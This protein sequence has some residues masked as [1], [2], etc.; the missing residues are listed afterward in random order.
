M[1]RRAPRTVATLHEN[2]SDGVRIV[3]VVLAASPVARV[4]DVDSIIGGWRLASRG[5]TIRKAA[6]EKGVSSG[7]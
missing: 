7:D 5:G 2:T 6:G 4:P 3:R 1:K